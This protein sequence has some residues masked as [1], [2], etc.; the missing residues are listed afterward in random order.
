MSARSLAEILDRLLAIRPSGGTHAF[1]QMQH[2]EDLCPLVEGRVRNVVDRYD[3]AQSIVYDIQ[4]TDDEGADVVVQVTG[5]VEGPE[6]LCFQIKSDT[7]MTADKLPTE[8]RAQYTQARDAYRPMIRYY[9]LPFADVDRQVARHGNWQRRSPVVSAIKEVFKRFPDVRVV[10]PEM[11]KTFVDLTDIRIDAFVKAVVG[12]DD[13]VLSQSR[14][15]L[16]ELPD[17]YAW[18]VALLC[19]TFVIDPTVGL[20]W[21]SIQLD[22]DLLPP[23]GLLGIPQ[24]VDESRA[25]LSNFVER[26]EDRV[27][28]SSA[29]SLRITPSGFPA[30]VALMHDARVRFGHTTERQ[31]VEYLAFLV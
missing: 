8:L 9:V 25:E 1:R 31:L 13:F 18:R 10:D 11:L 22:H 12:Q 20:E 26:L 28:E 23:E 29:R 19:A 17:G 21:D 5:Q 7:E 3:F 4:G 15:E 2:N 16:A 6:Y 24:T 27:T 30:T 14:Q